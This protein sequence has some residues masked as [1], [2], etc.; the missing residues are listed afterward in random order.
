MA[1]GEAQ[2]MASLNAVTDTGVHN[3]CPQPEFEARHTAS[4]DRRKTRQCL[5]REI[6]FI[7]DASF[8]QL[9]YEEVEQ[10]ASA[11]DVFVQKETKTQPS[12]EGLP[13][14]IGSLYALPLLT[15]RGEAALFRK[16]NFLK[17]WANTFRS[18]LDPRHPSPELIEEIK[19]LLNEAERV[20]SQLL[21]S[22]LR[23]IVSIA[24]RFANEHVSFDDLV[25]EGNY[26]LMKAVEKFDYSRGFRFSTYLT[27]SVQRHFYRHF[28]KTQRRKNTEFLST[29][30][31]VREATAVS[32]EPEIDIT[33][34]AQQQASKLLSR[35]DE[36]LND[37]EQFIVRERF[38]LNSSGKIR[39]LQSL[40]EDL[41]VCKERVRQV[42]HK[43]VRKLR[44]LALE[45]N[46]EMVSA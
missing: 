4:S 8:D 32:S 24:R 39:T 18:S 14:Y 29:E 42:F 7:Y 43:A 30:E 16:M 45:M 12:S 40:S 3:R 2:E 13:A 46:I 25:S 26:I 44:H 5:L 1:I 36:C 31:V 34:N 21:E 11:D 27:H 35:M 6:G 15:A 19:G 23:L 41:G 28:R 10:A 38:G 20:R 37:R 33:T 9:D 17:Y 22:N